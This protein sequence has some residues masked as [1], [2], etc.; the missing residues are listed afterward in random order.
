MSITQPP[1]P[2]DIKASTWHAIGAMYILKFLVP[3]QGAYLYYSVMGADP[4]K[5]RSRTEEMRAKNV[6]R[7]LDLQ[8]AEFLAQSSKTF[9]FDEKTSTPY[10]R[11]AQ[12]PEEE[13]GPHEIEDE[14]TEGDGLAE[15]A[16]R[17]LRSTL[18]PKK[19]QRPDE[20]GATTETTGQTDVD[21]NFEATK[22]IKPPPG[23]H[24]HRDIQRAL[25]DLLCTMGAANYASI[26]GGVHPTSPTCGTDLLRNI[27]N[28]IAPASTTTN[29]Q[30]KRA[31]TKHRESFGEHTNFG[32]W[33]T[34]LL[35]LQMTKKHLKIDNSERIDAM[36]DAIETIEE[37]TGPQ[38]RWSLEIMTWN[39]RAQS[40]QTSI[41][42]GNEALI[43]SFE[44]AMRMHQQ[45]RDLNPS[46]KEHAHQVLD[47]KPHCSWCFDNLGKRFNNHSVANCRNKERTDKQKQQGGG[48][49]PRKGRCFVCDDASHQARECPLIKKVKEQA[50]KTTPTESLE[51]QVSSAAIK[52]HDQYS[53]PVCLVASTRT[54]M[55]THSRAQ[56]DT[57]ATAT[58]T[59]QPAFIHNGLSR[60]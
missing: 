22:W 20:E 10:R 25:Y 15:A 9:D 49:Q 32:E 40:E 57:G 23:V 55:S 17:Y 18:T 39:I 46:S 59:D 5:K 60:L 26:V 41:K 52:E 44:N 43:T 45:K 34:T 35:L 58:M 19:T 21:G 13:E 31:Y 53:P 28:A 36:N 37:N 14:E 30:A 54:S 50:L 48:A 29:T 6:D 33:W 1:K 11:G 2:P 27:N 16:V 47:R 51:A 38:S 12:K 4:D 3:L 42:G 24:G 7:I 56:F 8:A